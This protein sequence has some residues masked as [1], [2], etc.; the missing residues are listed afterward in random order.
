MENLRNIISNL[1]IYQFQK[2][3]DYSNISINKS[4]NLDKSSRDPSPI[5]MNNSIHNYNEIPKIKNS[6]KNTN[7]IKNKNIRSYS[8]DYNI[9]PNNYY[10]K[11]NINYIAK[12]KELLKEKEYKMREERLKKENEALTLLLSQKESQ[13]KNYSNIQ[14]RLYD[15]EQNQKIK[16][17]NMRKK[18]TNKLFNKKINDNEKIR[19]QSSEIRQKTEPDNI[20]DEN[21]LKY[22]KNLGNSII[23]PKIKPETS[24]INNEILKNLNNNIMFLHKDYGRTPEYLEKMKEE[25]KLKKEEEKLKEKEKKLP[26]G[27]K[28]LPEEEKKER[29][30]ELFILKKDFENELFSL[31]IARLSKKQIE[32]KGEIEKKL[33]EIDDEINRLSY[34]EVVVKI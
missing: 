22:Y 6:I 19:S 25:L 20:I 34:K 17:K 11:P 29:L 24:P 1:Y 30:N 21:S 13:N 28:F 15:Y 4:N 3:N 12:N 31:P 7:K 2:G 32:R 16:K 26:K 27:T 5:P 33:D 23:L 9:I 8:P 18:L 10:A 14:S